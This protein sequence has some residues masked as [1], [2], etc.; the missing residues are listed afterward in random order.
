MKT[1]ELGFTL[2]DGKKIVMATK[3]FDHMK[4]HFTKT[5]FYEVSVFLL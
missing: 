2:T 3:L 5:M 1:G 4:A